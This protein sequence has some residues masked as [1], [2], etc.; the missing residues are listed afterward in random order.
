MFLNRTNRT[1][2]FY[3]YLKVRTKTAATKATDKFMEIIG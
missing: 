2:T 1:D 3:T